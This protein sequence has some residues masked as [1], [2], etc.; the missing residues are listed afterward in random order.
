M[1]G[2]E[3]IVFDTSSKGTG[4]PTWIIWATVNTDY[5]QA[6]GLTSTLYKSVNGGATWAPVA[7]P[8]NVTVR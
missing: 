5:A 7:V 8:S 4:Q 1:I 2:V 3:Q 6:A